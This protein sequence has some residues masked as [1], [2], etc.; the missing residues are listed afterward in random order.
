MSDLDTIKNSV[1]FLGVG[2]ITTD[3]DPE[4]EYA[5]VEWPTSRNL[6][7]LRELALCFGIR[8]H[9]SIDR[10]KADAVTAGQRLRVVSLNEGAILGATLCSSEVS[11]YWNPGDDEMHRVGISSPLDRLNST[12]IR[13]AIMATRPHVRLETARG[14]AEH[15]LR[16]FGEVVIRTSTL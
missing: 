16:E 7:V 8:S 5:L 4:S 14:A 12:K 2:N 6:E 11:V 10:V 13:Q 15:I 1:Y 3:Y 9:I